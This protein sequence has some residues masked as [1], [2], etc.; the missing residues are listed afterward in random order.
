MGRA[1][2]TS[3]GPGL[4]AFGGSLRSGKRSAFD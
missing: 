4:S 2:V 3:C 1:A